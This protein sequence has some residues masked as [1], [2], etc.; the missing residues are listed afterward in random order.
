MH[1][2]ITMTDLD[3]LADVVGHEPDCGSY[4]TM[5]DTAA[6]P[7]NLPCDC[8]A[9]DTAR[10]VRDAHDIPLVRVLAWIDNLE[11]ELVAA[12][13]ERFGFTLTDYADILKEPADD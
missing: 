5:A 12:A 2:A 6:T 3:K 13:E 11:P 8:G 7:L 10:R 9:R 1:G 4:A